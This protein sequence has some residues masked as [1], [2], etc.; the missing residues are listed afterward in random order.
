MV[1]GEADQSGLGDDKLVPE[2]GSMLIFT[3]LD[4]SLLDHYS[5]S[6]APAQPLMQRLEAQQIPVML[7]T[8]K[9][10]AEVE[11]LR[12]QLLNRH[13]FIVENGA[14]IFI[15]VGYF[16]EQPPLT[17]VNGDYWVREFSRPRDHWLE[18][19]RQALPH[20]P[21]MFDHFAIMS[22]EQ[23]AA[24]TG[25]DL[26]D[27]QRSRQRGYGEPIQWLGEADKRQAFIQWLESQGGHLLQGGRFL[28][29][30]DQCDKGA[31][32]LW[33]EQ[34]FR[35]QANVQNLTTL[36]IGDSGNDVAMLDAADIALIIRSPVHPPPKL[37][38]R[39]GVYYSEEAGP[40]GWAS[41]VNQ[42]LTSITR[43]TAV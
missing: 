9:T 10:Q 20:F 39:Q 35:R 1:E 15:P 3:D 42:I 24:C 32:L 12:H 13:P 22:A 14:A 25:L 40:E 31:A 2:V 43:N 30:C 33:M 16:P 6:F 7:I 29:L 18:L 27:A 36:A 17:H 19:L 5:Y 28:H 34:E 38:R 4:G 11:L 21:G 8:S 26:A 23:I 37:Q 41:G